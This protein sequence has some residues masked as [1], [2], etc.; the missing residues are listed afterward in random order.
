MNMKKNT[1]SLLLCLFLC[2]GMTLVSCDKPEPEEPDVTYSIIGHWK[3]DNAFQET[4]YNHVDMTNMYGQNFQLIFKED[5]TLITTDGINETE[6]QWTLNGD[7]LGFIQ[8]AGMAPV[9]YT[10]LKLTKDS[11]SIENGSGTDYV[12]TMNLHR[13]Y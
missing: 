10:V 7:Q 11:L 1:F 2:L 9:M 4:P 3:L 12:T 8:A 13:V 5:S 6:M